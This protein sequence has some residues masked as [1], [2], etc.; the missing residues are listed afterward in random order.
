MST[1]NAAAN[2]SRFRRL[3]PAGTNT[4]TVE[5]VDSLQGCDYSVLP[6]RIEAGT[7]LIGAV[8][9]AGD[10]LVEAAAPAPAVVPTVD[11]LAGGAPLLEL[12]QCRERAGD[13]QGDHGE[14]H[15]GAPAA[16]VDAA[17][18]GHRA[19]DVAEGALA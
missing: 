17:V 4:I 14:Q 18:D 13:R 15:G 8:M 11:E 6:D 9:T 3:A 5:G 7:Y 1:A 2:I 16:A 10:V 19:R 12:L